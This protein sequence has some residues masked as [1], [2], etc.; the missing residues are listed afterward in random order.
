MD[1]WMSWPSGTL[2]P[3]IEEL[4]SFCDLDQISLESPLH[5]ESCLPR[6]DSPHFVLPKLSADSP[7][8][9]PKHT[10]THSTPIKM[11]QDWHVKFDHFQNL[12]RLKSAQSQALMLNAM[13]YRTRSPSQ[14][15]SEAMISDIEQHFQEA[16]KDSSLVFNP[17]KLGFIPTKAWPDGEQ[18]F[19]SLVTNFFQKRNSSNCR[20]IHKLFNALQLAKA[21]PHLCRVIGVEWIGPDILRVDKHAF[22]RLL[23]IRTI[24]GSLFHQQGNFP[25]HGFVELSETKARECLPPEA[26]A[27]VDYESVRLLTHRDRL[28]H[29]ECQAQDVDDCKYVSVRKR[30]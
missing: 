15:K 14:I 9:Q 30:E 28:F 8:P 11:T 13:L 17:A 26:L 24:D 25:S 20:F 27:D 19:G 18:T 2:S 6:L 21:A 4:P 10:R 1:D 29:R 3:Q 16:I 5:F 22:A 7:H 12:H 23:K